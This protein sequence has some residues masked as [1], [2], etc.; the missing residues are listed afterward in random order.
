MFRTDSTP[1]WPNYIPKIKNFHMKSRHQCA[2]QIHIWHSH[3]WPRVEEPDRFGRNGHF[4][5]IW[6]KQKLRIDLKWRKMWTKV[7]FGHPKWP[8][9]AILWKKKKSCVLIWNDEKCDQKWFSLI[10]NGHRRPFYEKFKE[11]K[12]YVLI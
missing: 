3:W 4:E 1:T 7:I 5:K 2:Y 8:P 12:S 6:W 11:I 9:V 10:Q